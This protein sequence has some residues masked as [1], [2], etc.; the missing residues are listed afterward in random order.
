MEA[1][2]PLSFKVRLL[3]KSIVWR[4]HQDH[5]RHRQVTSTNART[6]NTPHLADVDWPV[7]DNTTD[8]EPELLTNESEEA[9]SEASVIEQPGEELRT[10]TVSGDPVSESVNRDRETVS[11]LPPRRNPRHGRSKPKR[12]QN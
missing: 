4:R 11:S 9:N 1:T 7:I 12:H 3:D 2:G 5:L 6:K 10:E 8:S